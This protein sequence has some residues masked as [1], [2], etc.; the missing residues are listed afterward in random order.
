[1]TIITILATIVTA[2][3]AVALWAA[4]RVRR[5]T[6]KQKKALLKTSINSVFSWFE[7]R[8]LLER[9]PAFI[10]DYERLYPRLKLLEEGYEDVRT[11]WGISSGACCRSSSM[12]RADD[13]AGNGT[14][15]GCGSVRVPV[16]SM[17]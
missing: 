14:T 16:T 17:T 15:L 4:W 10:Y 13:V 8:E 12:V 7:E 9:T 2:A 1:M 3:L 6:T 11:N 5:M